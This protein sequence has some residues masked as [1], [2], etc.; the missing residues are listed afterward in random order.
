M[1][2]HRSS[3]DSSDRPRESVI[4]SGHPLQSEFVRVILGGVGRSHFDLQLDETFVSKRSCKVAC[5]F[6]TKYL[7][8]PASNRVDVIILHFPTFRNLFFPFLNSSSLNWIIKVEKILEVSRMDIFL[9][10]WILF[11]KEFVI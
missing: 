9:K 2:A 1:K 4:P 7:L 10:W 3:L 6:S 8:F 11:D 5:S